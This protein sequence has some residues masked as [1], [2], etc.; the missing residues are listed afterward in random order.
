MFTIENINKKCMSLIRVHKYSENNNFFTLYEP[1]HH[2]TRLADEKN[3]HLKSLHLG[4]LSIYTIF[5]N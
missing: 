3:S 5:F 1:M 2:R 4:G